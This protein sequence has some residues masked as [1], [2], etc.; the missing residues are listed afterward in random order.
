MHNDD[1]KRFESLK[2]NASK[3]SV[4][5]SIKYDVSLDEHIVS[6]GKDLR[7]LLGNE[8]SVLIAASTHQ[9]EDEQIL[10]AYKMAKEKIEDLLLIL[11]PRHPE[12]FDSVSELVV[13]NGL[14][15]IRRSE[16]NLSEVTSDTDVY[17]GDTMGEML[18]MMAAS[19]IVF[20]GGVL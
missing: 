7:R 4:T 15:I 16:T 13:S 18:I 17:L 8:R 12:R 2:V 11:V 3:I 6:W 19:D 10:Q 14:K 9:G 1:S 20:M 5:G